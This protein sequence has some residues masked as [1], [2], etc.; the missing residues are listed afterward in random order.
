MTKLPPLKVDVEFEDNT[1]DT[2]KDMNLI[3]NMTKSIGTVYNNIISAGITYLSTQMRVVR[4]E[5][6]L[7]DAKREMNR[8]RMRHYEY[9]IEDARISAVRAQQALYDVAQAGDFLTVRKAQL[10]LKIAERDIILAE[11]DYAD[12]KRNSRE[13]LYDAEKNL[14][15]VQW[16]TI[17]AVTVSIAQ[18]MVFIGKALIN[19]KII[20][21]EIATKETAEAIMSFGASVGKTAAIIT[22]VLAMMAVAWVSVKS[23]GAQ[24]QPETE[25]IKHVTELPFQKKEKNIT[26]ICP[27]EEVGWEVWKAS[28]EIEGGGQQIFSSWNIYNEV[29]IY[30]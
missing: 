4:G 21:A 15:I 25:G 23:M 26:I 17:A 5:R 16:A 11:M 27:N 30:A 8:F 9:S 2:K 10:D 29:S 20:W 14:E 6:R 12:K 28:R 13:E 22:T 24:T 3:A 1:S 18:N 19:A 7:A